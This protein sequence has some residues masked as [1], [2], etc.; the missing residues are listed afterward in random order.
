MKSGSLKAALEG[1]L[2]R[3]VLAAQ[4]F[5]CE[6]RGQGLFLIFGCEGF[7][8]QAALA[9]PGGETCCQQ[10]LT[11]LRVLPRAVAHVAE[12]QHEEDRAVTGQGAIHWG[13]DRLPN[14]PGAPLVFLVRG[15][16]LPD[17]LAQ[18][19]QTEVPAGNGSEALGAGGQSLGSGHHVGAQ[20]CCANFRDGTQAVFFQWQSS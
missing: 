7:V 3:V 1:L 15:Q 18:A 12:V 9:A 14:L 16:P 4:E 10:F 5:G 20:T 11:R 8:D 2:A 17:A 13:F 6:A 19:L